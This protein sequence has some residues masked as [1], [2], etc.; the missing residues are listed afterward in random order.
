MFCGA[1]VLTPERPTDNR[2]N[3][4][5]SCVLAAS[6]TENSRGGS[7]GTS[8]ANDDAIVHTVGDVPAGRGSRLMVERRAVERGTTINTIIVYFEVLDYK[9]ITI[10]YGH[11]KIVWRIIWLLP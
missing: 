6:R 1:V 10:H 11:M 3:C 5:R 4:V 7:H 2:K 8:R 9:D